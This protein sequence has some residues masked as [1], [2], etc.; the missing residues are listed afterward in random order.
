MTISQ[1]QEEARTRLRIEAY[2]LMSE[3]VKAALAQPHA[4]REAAL[5]A[6]AEEAGGKIWFVSGAHCVRLM[7]VS[8]TS[9]IGY[10]YAA[11]SWLR[12]AAKRKKLL[13]DQ[14]P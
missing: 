4:E 10:I 11:D 2:R 5:R 9:T 12:N 13:E 6:L 3:D 8:G 14:L 7:G 1:A